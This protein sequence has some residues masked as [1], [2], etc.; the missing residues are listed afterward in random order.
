[1]NRVSALT[2]QPCSKNKMLSEHTDEVS[3]LRIQ[4][5]VTHTLS[6]TLNAIFLKYL[7]TPQKLSIK[8][9]EKHSSINHHHQ[10]SQIRRY[11]VN[12]TL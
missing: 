4:H 3:D 8:P 6:L 10:L 12:R 2:I 9:N 11:I 7:T 1:M 5:A